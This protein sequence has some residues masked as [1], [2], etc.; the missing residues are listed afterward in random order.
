MT[1][2]MGIVYD[3]PFAEYLAIDAAHATSLI[4]YWKDSPKHGR[5]HDEHRHETSAMADGKAF[6]AATVEPDRFAR[7][8][9]PK[10]EGMKFSTKEGKAWQAEQLAAGRAI[11]EHPAAV[12]GMRDAVLAD[13]YARSYLDRPGNAEVS[14]FWTDE[15][16]GLACKARF[17]YLCVDETNVGLKSSLSLD[18]R[19]FKGDATKR[20]YMLQ[21]ALYEDAAKACGLTPP[22]IIEI[23]VE[24]TP[25]HDVTVYRVRGRALAKGHADA[26]WALALYA[27]A[28][29]TGLYP[30]RTSGVVDFEPPEWADNGDEAVNTEGLEVDDE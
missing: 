20:G 2:P 5:H 26:R 6:H 22:E 17:D 25:P 27:E 8:F 29:R 13:E 9:A 23:C 21:W 18:P 3:L 19:W 12:L 7:E 15:R 10:P 14:L 28:E 16:T 30:G 11:I 24:N 1:I 4:H